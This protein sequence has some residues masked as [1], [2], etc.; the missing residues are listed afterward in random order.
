MNKMKSTEKSKER[1]INILQPGPKNKAC[2]EYTLLNLILVLH[3]YLKKKFCR[4]LN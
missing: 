3:P 2:A 4:D 1:G